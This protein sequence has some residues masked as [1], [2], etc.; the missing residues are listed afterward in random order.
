[1]YLAGKG[2]G[3]NGAVEWED[4]PPCVTQARELLLHCGRCYGE[5]EDIAINKLVVLAWVATGSRKVRPT[6]SS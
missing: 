1:M 2:H 5:N 3:N 4:V 6:A